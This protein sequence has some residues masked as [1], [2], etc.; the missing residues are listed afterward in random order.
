MCW[1]ARCLASTELCVRGR[2]SPTRLRTFQIIINSK[3]RVT[4]AVSSSLS[5]TIIHPVICKWHQFSR[6]TSI[7]SSNVARTSLIGKNSRQASSSLPIGIKFSRCRDAIEIDQILTLFA[8]GIGPSLKRHTHP[9]LRVYLLHITP[10][11]TIFKLGLYDML[12]CIYRQTW[13]GLTCSSYSFYY[14]ICICIVHCAVH[15]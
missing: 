2:F 1:N 14:Y 5:Y 7:K 8:R 6:T 11:K 9:S 12:F 13:F 4:S 10:A 15:G 3:A